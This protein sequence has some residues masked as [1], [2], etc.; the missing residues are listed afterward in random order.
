ML[1]HP[2]S[3]TVVILLQYF[4]RPIASAAARRLWAE[5]DGHHVMIST[6]LP[7]QSADAR[8]RRL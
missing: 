1:I 8:A 4:T 2:V 7:L 6:I 3:G 5:Q